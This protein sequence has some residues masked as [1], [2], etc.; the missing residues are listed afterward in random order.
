MLN[1]FNKFVKQHPISYGTHKSIYKLIMMGW[2]T[3][4]VI[5][6]IIVVGILITALTYLLMRIL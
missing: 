1:G 5:I 6:G 4:Y 3:T 2:F